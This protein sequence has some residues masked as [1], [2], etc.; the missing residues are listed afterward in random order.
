MSNTEGFRMK[1]EMS[2][3]LENKKTL[4]EKY[5]S[6]TWMLSL[7]RPE[8]YEGT[9]SG[10]INNGT[11][12]NPTWHLVNDH[13]PE[14]FEK[15]RSPNLNYEKELKTFKK[16]EYFNKTMKEYKISLDNINKW[17]YLNVTGKDLLKTERECADL[18]TG[19][20]FLYSKKEIEKGGIKPLVL[21]SN[22]NLGK[23]LNLK[24]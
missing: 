20:K 7:R 16:N 4:E 24:Y 17:S 19:R 2:S 14:V 21:R 6:K 8:K 11:H 3:F 1:T 18:L 9:W 12:V 5:G 15:I 10:Y 23:V 22:Y 13:P